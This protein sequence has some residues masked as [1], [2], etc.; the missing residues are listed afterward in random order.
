MP[1]LDGFRSRYAR[2][3]EAF[4][5]RRALALSRARRERCA[6]LSR[7][8]GLR[9]FRTAA[10]IARATGSQKACGAPPRRHGQTGDKKHQGHMAISVPVHDLV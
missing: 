1:Y 6:E 7:G 3:L 5:P 9:A 10:T 8:L 2:N 4:D